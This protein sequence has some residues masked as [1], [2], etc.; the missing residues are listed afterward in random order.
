[1]THVLFHGLEFPPQAG[2]VGAYMYN[3]GCALRGVGVGVTVLT[4]Q[5]LVGPRRRRVA[6]RAGTA[7]IR[8]RRGAPHARAELLLNIKKY[9]QIEC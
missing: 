1:M 5:V 2:G 7:R 6:L 3:M 4:S 8:A 9:C